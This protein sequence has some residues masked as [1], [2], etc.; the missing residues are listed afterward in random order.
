MNSPSIHFAKKAESAPRTKVSFAALFIAFLTTAFVMFVYELTKQTLFPQI[1]IWESHTITIVF[2]AILATYAVARALGKQASAHAEIVAETR[3]RIRAEESAKALQV[4]TALLEESNVAMVAEVQWRETI[5]RELELREDQL[6]RQAFEDALTGLPNRAKFAEV[7]SEALANA[8]SSAGEKRFALVFVDIDRF[9]YVNDTLG[10]AAGDGVLRAI[11]DRLRREVAA[12]D[13]VAR[14]GGDEFTILLPN[15]RTMEGA[16]RTAA[17][18]LRVIE[19]PISAL[20]HQIVVTAS[21]GVAIADTAVDRSDQILSDADLAMYHA[22][23]RGRG[24]WEPFRPALRTRS[25]AR[26]ELEHDLRGAIDRAEL[27]V[28]YQPIVST[29]TGRTLAFEALLRWD[30]PRLGQ[31]GPAVFIPIAEETGNL[32][33]LGD[34]VLMRACKDAAI[35]LREAAPNNS[36][37]VSVN[38]SGSQLLSPNFAASVRNAL[39]LSGLP[40]SH[41]RLEIT[42]KVIVADAIAAGAVLAQLGSLGV[43]LAIDDFGTGHSALSY[44][45]QLPVAIVKLDQYFVH[46]MCAEPRCREIVSAII[47]LGS[48]LGMTVIAEGVETEEQLTVLR[49]LKC[50]LVQGFFIAR[51]LTDPLAWIK[52]YKS[53]TPYSQVQPILERQSRSDV[54]KLIGA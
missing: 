3:E 15:T 31:V 41:L 48:A 27:R 39:E 29:H 53:G 50:P 23:E 13:I 42:E 34:W 10:H 54:L 40:S 25:L 2:G 19:Q 49:E 52:G 8:R 38:V 30:H 11:G 33:A 24:R 5:Q 45:H 4:R 18:L 12:D 51:P 26:L 7:L 14:L 44:L 28:E 43:A 1:S 46:R 32:I 35:W 6:S 47:G 20:G 37:A 9:K 21:A 16:E 17:R 22:K 36:P